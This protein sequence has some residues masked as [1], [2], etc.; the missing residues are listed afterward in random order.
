MVLREVERSE[1]LKVKGHTKRDASGDTGDW[2]SYFRSRPTEFQ[3]CFTSDCD[4]FY[5]TPNTQNPRIFD[6]DGWIGSI[7]MSCHQNPHDGLTYEATKALIEVAL[8]G[9]EEV[10]NWKKDNHVRDCPKRGALI[11]GEFECNH[12]ERILYHIHIC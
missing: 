11:E 2:T 7:C 8:K 10:T 3:Y 5:G 6:C 12:M 1:E 9:D 4:R